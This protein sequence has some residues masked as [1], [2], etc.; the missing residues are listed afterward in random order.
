MF[1]INEI[2]CILGP[3][4]RPKIGLER[5][6]LSKKRLLMAALCFGL[7]LQSPSLVSS[8]D[9]SSV[10]SG[11]QKCN[12]K[13]LTASNKVEASVS[14]VDEVAALKLPTFSISAGGFKLDSGDNESSAYVEASQPIYSFGK[15][16]SLEAVALYELDLENAKYRQAVSDHVSDLVTNLIQRDALVDEIFVLD[17]IIEQ[18]AEFVAIVE[19][20]AEQGLSSEADLREV[21]SEYLADKSMLAEKELQL[22]NMDA[23]LN[24]LSCE[25]IEYNGEILLLLSGFEFQNGEVSILNAPSY[26]VKNAELDLKFA[27]IDETLKSEM[28]SIVAKGRV[29]KSNTDKTLTSRIGVSIDYQYEGLGRVRKAKISMAKIRAKEAENALKTI[30]L[31]L[32]QEA[33][34]NQSRIKIIRDELIPMLQSEVLL[35]EGKN[36]S[37]LRLYE[38]SRASVREVVSNLNQLKAAKFS[39]IDA[40]KRLRDAHNFVG[41]SLGLYAPE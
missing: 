29:G 8:A 14:K 20:R 15:Q 3:K 1:A 32:N 22:K 26:V 2:A 39:V 27:E 25:N 40:T 38:A 31:E 33:T 12:P 13:L 35:A 28:P 4:S 5:G 37:I 17:G 34:S 9:L 19:R 11:L 10:I 16:K 23:S 24:A 18:K 30:K 7:T 21:R 41:N 6:K 36:A